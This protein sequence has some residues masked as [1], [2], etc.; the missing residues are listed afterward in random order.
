M[1][2][3]H[4]NNEERNLAQ[5]NA[6]RVLWTRLLAH[7]KSDSALTAKQTPRN[8]EC[9]GQGEMGTMLQQKGLLRERQ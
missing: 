8:D 1:P 6:W 9:K 3:H 7:R 4:G 2:M 5:V